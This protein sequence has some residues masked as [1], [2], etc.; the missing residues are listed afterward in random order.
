MSHYDTIVIGAGQAGLAA[1]Y[2]LQRAG[3]R[4]TLLD[5]GR[6]PG[7][8]WRNR[9]DSL[10]LF[11][12]TRYNGLPGLKF[13]GAP[14]AFPAKE[15]VADYFAY[16]ARVFRI[17]IRFGA[18]VT[19]LRREGNAFVVATSDG[20]VLTASSVIVATGANQRPHV[21]DFASSLDPKIV[22]MHS[23]AYR[24]PDSVPQ[25]TVL[26]VGA[27]NSGAQIAIELAESGRDVILS[28]R[29]T[30]LMPRR[31]LGRDIYD[32]IWPTILQP[33]VNSWIGRRLMKGR[34]FS[35]DPLVGIPASAL[36]R[37]D[38]SRAG[39]TVS[40]KAGDPVLEDG[41]V[42]RD[43]AAI[44][45]STG[46]R[47]DYDWIDL[48]VL[49]LDGY[50]EHRR[51]VATIVPGLGFI[52]MRFQHRMRSALLGGVGEDAEHVVR[53]IAAKVLDDLNR[54]GIPGEPLV[55]GDQGHRLDDRLRD[56]HPIEWVAMQGR[57]A[58]E[59]DGMLA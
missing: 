21:P 11:T 28:G 49:G 19:E 45:W 36:D 22:Q 55:R 15:D 20:T 33:T 41:R 29:D 57:Q 38:L 51:G 10:R 23:S 16:Y 50:P 4:F 1:G 32:W 46:Y 40:T 17:P 37:P 59:R 24:R 25:G 53:K 34:L 48:P 9:W 14:Y 35:G 30:G 27:G 58:R 52:G 44:V 2:F 7:D 18:R 8:S 26:V 13:P 39:R 3:L 54:S 47:P 31:F 43:L 5:A 56:Q 42:L 6:Q 12:P